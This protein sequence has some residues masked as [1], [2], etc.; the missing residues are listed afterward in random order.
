MDKRL[1]NITLIKDKYEYLSD[2][3]IIMHLQ[4]YNIVYNIY[5]PFIANN[6][7]D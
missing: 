4:K 1:N 3:T 2:K 7:K 5:E 6:I